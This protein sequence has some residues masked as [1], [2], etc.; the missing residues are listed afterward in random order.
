MF[1]FSWVRWLRSR[2]MPRVQQVRK[3]INRGRTR[4]ALEELEQRLA[5][6]TY[7]WDGGGGDGSWR[8]PLNWVSNTAPTAKVTTNDNLIF[9]TGVSILNTTN[10]LLGLNPFIASI[11]FN[12]GGYTVGGNNLTIGSGGV[13][14]NAGSNTVNLNLSS[15]IASGS[16]FSV[17]AGAGLTVG[18]SVSSALTS[19]N[20]IN[21]GASSNVTVSGNVSLA[22]GASGNQLF[23]NA[24]T[25]ANVLISGSLSGAGNVE[26][27]KEGTGSLT[28]RGNNSG[29]GSAITVRAGVV[30]IE[31]AS[32]LGSTSAGTTVQ[33]NA[34]VQVRSGVGT[35]SENIRVS[36]SGVSGDG[37]L[38]NSGGANTWAGN[39]VMDSSSVL[40]VA[41]GSIDITGVI[42]D[43]GSGNNLTKEG[44]GQ[45]I[46]SNANTYRGLTT[47]N[48]GVVTIKH[49]SAL[50]TQGTAANG[51]VVQNLTAQGKVATLQLDGSVSP[52]TILDEQ[53]T[54]NGP[55][56]SSQ[57][58]LNNVAGNNVWA[59][60]IILGG[61]APNGS[62]ANLGVASGTTLLVS[63]VIST[64]NS[65][66]NVSKVGG[67]KLIL[68]NANT[69]TGITFI[70]SGIV[71]IRDS[72][73]LGPNGSGNTVVS[74]GA[75]LELEVDTGFDAHGRNLANDSVL[76]LNGP[77]P[78][79]GLSINENITL[80]GSGISNT[81]AL[82][83]LSGINKYVGDITMSGTVAIGVEPDPDPSNTKAYFTDDYSLTITG[84]LSGNN[85]RKVGAGHMILPEDNTYTGTTRIE[86]GWIT[87]QSEQALGALAGGSDASQPATT[88]LAGAAL[89]LKPLN[90]G[91]NF[92]LIKN[93]VLSGVGVDHPFPIIDQKGALMSLGGDNKIGGPVNNRTSAIKLDG[94][95]G[96][97]VENAFDE[98][99]NELTITAQMS[100]FGSTPGGITK[101]GSRRL[102]LQGE[103]T[104][105]GAVD[106]SEGVILTQNATALGL[107]TTGAFTGTNTYTNTTTT[108]G[109]GAAELQAFSVSGSGTFTLTFNGVSTGNLSPSSSA[110]DVEAALNGLSSMTD[111]GG[112]VAVTK[113]KTNFTVLFGGALVGVNVLELVITGPGLTI[114]KSTLVQG[115]GAALEVG[116][117]PAIN[118]G[119]ISAGIAIWHERLVLGGT[120]NVEFALAPLTLRSNDNL[121]Q[122]PVT[123]REDAI[124]QVPL[125]ARLVFLGS[126]DDDPNT[127]DSGSSLTLAGGGQMVL[128]GA[129]TYRGTTFVNEGL[130]VIQN[131]LA[132]GGTGSPE[133]QLVTITGATDG[134]FTLTFN[135][136]TTNALSATASETDVENALNALPSVAGVGGNVTVEKTGNVYTVLFD[137]NLSSLNQALMS[138]AGAGGTSAQVAPLADGSGGTIVADGAALQLQGSLTV[139]GE[140]LLLEGE[141]TA[142]NSNVPVGWFPI[143]PAPINGWP[144]PGNQAVTGRITGVV[145][146][147]VNTDIIYIS[148]A[149]GGA[150][151]TI[152]GGRTWSPLFDYRNGQAEVQQITVGGSSGTFTLSFDGADTAELPVGAS[153]LAVQGALNS[154]LTIGGAFGSVTVSKS[155]NTY[156][157]TFAG[158]LGGADVSQITGSGSA[159]VT[160]TPSTLTE[161]IDSDALL[162][163]GTISMDPSDARTIYIGTG[164]ANNSSDSYYGT[165]IYKSVDSGQTWSLVTGKQIQTVTVS[166]GGGSSTFRLSFDGVQTS[167]MNVGA[168]ETTVENNL[169]GLSTIQGRG[170]VDVTKTGN[171][172]KIEFLGG[173]ATTE[174][175][176]LV[177][178]G[179]SGARVS[180]VSTSPF[181]PFAG[182]GISK[183]IIDS[184][185]SANDRT[186]YVASGDGGV[187]ADEVQRLRFSGISTFKLSF[188]GVD[189]NG[190]IVT[191]E[192][193]DI[194]YNN[195]GQTNRDATA[196]AIKTALEALSNIG[197][198]GGI[199]TV[200]PPSGGFGGNSNRYTVTFGG[201]LTQKNVQ[202]LTS[203][204]GAPASQF[205]SGITI[206]TFREGGGGKVVNGTPGGAGVWRF[207]GGAW[208]NLTAVVSNNRDSTA[209]TNTD[210]NPNPPDTPGP[211]DDYRISFPQSSATWSDVALVYTSRDNGS[212]FGPV[213]YAALGIAGGNANNGVFWSKNPTSNSPIWYVGAPGGT[214]SSPATAPTA[215]DAR[216][217]SQFPAGSSLGNIKLDAVGGSTLITTTVYASTA[218]S[219]GSLTA[220]YKT[221]DGGHT[222]AAATSPGNYM[223]NL[224]GYANA[225]LASGTTI[226]VAGYEANSSTHAQHIFRSTDSGSNWTDISKDS[227][228]N[229]PHTGTH[230][231]A[232]VGGR[233]FTGTD[234]GLWALDSSGWSDLNGNL[235]ISQVNSVASHPFDLTV[236]YAGVQNNGTAMFDNALGWTAIDG[237]SGG[238]I[239]VDPSNPSILYHVLL[240]PGSSTFVRRSTNGGASWTNILSPAGANVP[241]IL[242]NVDTSRL[243]VGG[244]T[245]QESLDQG[246]TWRGLSNPIVANGVAIPSYQGT[247]VAD[248]GFNHVTDIGANTYDADTVYVTN[249]SRVYVTKDHGLTWVERTTDLEDLG[250][251]SSLLVD[252]RN[253]DTVYVTRSA[254]GGEKVLVTTDAGRSWTDI[255]NDLPDM[256]VWKLVLDTRSGDIYVGT[257]LGVWRLES[258]T[259]TWERFGAGMP[260]VQVRDL[261]LNETT[262]ILLAGTYGRSVYQLF[263]GDTLANPGALR[264]VSGAS[265]WAGP[266]VLAGDTTIRVDGTQAIQNGISAAS[267]NLIGVVGELTPGQN[268]LLV[269][270]GGGDL[271]LSGVNVYGGTT[272]VQAGLLSIKN[273]QALGSAGTAEVQTL[274]IGGSSSGTFTL[275][276]NGQTTGPLSATAS[277]DEVR[278]A[279]NALSSMQDVGGVASVNQAGNVYTITFG[280]SLLGYDQPELIAASAD[281]AD[282]VIATVGAGAGATIIAAGAILHLQSNLDLEPLTLGGDGASFNGHNTGALRNVSGNNTY[283]G[284]LTLTGSTTIGVDSGSSLTISG[285]IDDGAGAFNLTK[286]LTGTLVLAGANSYGGTTNVNQGILLAAN[287]DALGTS[288]GGTRVLN[289]AQLQLAGGITVVDEDLTLSG[290]GISGAGALQSLSGQNT[291]DGDLTLDFLPGFSPTTIPPDFVGFGVEDGSTLIIDG[292]I[293]QDTVG[294]GSPAN[295][296]VTKTGNG[297]LVFKGANSYGGLT[298]VADGI[299]NIQ[300]STALGTGG[301]ASSGTVIADGAILELEHATGITLNGE[302]LTLSGDGVAGGGVVRNISGNNTFAG[303]QNVNLQNAVTMVVEGTSSLTFEGA[304]L[305]PVPPPATPVTLTKTGTGTLVLK[306]DNVYGASTIDDGTLQVDGKIGDVSID[307]GTLAGSGNVGAMTVTSAGGAVHPGTSPGILKALSA[308]WNSSTLF[309]VELVDASTSG[310]DQLI[311]NGTIEISGAALDGTVATTAVTGDVFTIIS[312]SQ[313]NGEFNGLPDDTVFYFGGRRFRIDYTSTT[314]ELTALKD[315]STIALQ[316]SVTPTVFGQSVD[317]TATVSAVPPGT[318]E[319]TGDVFF[320]DGA[321]PLGFATLSGGVAVFTIST[322]GIGTHPIT[323]S[324]GGD[325]NFNAPASDASVIQ[326]VNQVG[327]TTSIASSLNPS[328][329]ADLVTFT[330]TVA[331]LPPGGGVPTGTVTFFHGATNIGSSSLDGAGQA[332]FDVSNFTV[333][334]HSLSAVYDGDSNYL[335]STSATFTQVVDK[336]A[337]TTS[338]ASSDTT[339]IYGESVTFTATVT[340]VVTPTGTVT[341]MDGA[342][343]LGSDDLDGS[344]QAVFVISSLNAGSH[345]I[346]AVYEGDANLATSTS[347]EV[348]QEIARAATTMIVV[349][350]DNPSAIGQSVTFTATVTGIGV[351][352]GSVLFK[353]GTTTLGTGTLS[354]GVATFST[355]DL[356][357]GTHIIV[358]EYVGDDNNDASS[359]SVTQDV[360][361]ASSVVVSSSDSTTAFGEGVTFTAVVRGAMGEATG[362][363][364]FFS[365]ATSLGAPVTLSGGEASIFV[366]SLAVGL[367]GVVARYSGDSTYVDSESAAFT[368]TVSKAGTSTSLAS[369]DDTSTFGDSVDFTATV[370]VVAPGA[371]APTGF[372]TFRDNGSFLATV[373][374]SGNTAILST[375][376][377]SGGSHSIT[378]TY[379]GDASFSSSS[380]SVGQTVAAAASTTS[381]TST[382]A[383]STYG[384]SVTFTA[385]V[386]SAAGTPT[387]TV[388]FKNGTTELGSRTLSGGVATLSTSA[389]VAGSYT[390][391]AEYQ[392]DGNFDASAGSTSQVVVKASTST[393]LGSSKNPSATGE[394]VTFT[395]TVSGVGTLGGQ[396]IFTIDGI[397]GDPVALSD[398]VATFSTSALGFGAHAITARFMGDANHNGSSSNTVTQD[399]LH[400]T[401]TVVSGTP[402]S[403]SVGESVTFTATI[404]G[405]GALATG[406][407][408]FKDNGVQIGTGTATDG[409]ATFTTSALLAGTHSITAHYAGDSTHAGSASGA[410]SYQVGKAN[411]ST[412]VVSSASPS[413]F[414]QSVTF[415][416]TVTVPGTTATGTVTFMDGS[417]VLG[418]RTLSG[419]PAT[420]AT[421]SL[422]S[423]N[424]SITVVYNGDTN[425]LGSTSSAITQTVTFPLATSMK[426]SLSPAFG[427]G[428]NSPFTLSV[429][430]YDVFGNVAIGHNQ[431]V[432]LTLLSAPVGGTLTGTLSKTFSSGFVSFSDLRVTKAGSYTIRITSG[433]LVQDITVTTIGRRV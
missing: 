5:P 6:A 237:G 85:L 137:G 157:I 296:G 276:F 8:N 404:S 289:G 350:S 10:D 229:G 317:F 15:G 292:V 3:L 219:S 322:L 240:Q 301:G 399:V 100:D 216:S 148:T 187:G 112:S 177:G 366:S 347:N 416:A 323:A 86:Q 390:I 34:E 386:S 145:A 430:A 428:I 417:T 335:G 251:L 1:P 70:Q 232:L 313:V 214:N 47:I 19:G 334:S 88:V 134:S 155:G 162:Y 281:G 406:S 37:V 336:A 117:V 392:G 72:K 433:T 93:L 283:S 28:L 312:A 396:V 18:G 82:R 165:G 20:L 248:P 332:T 236:A 99:E 348:T 425:Y 121:W 211:D 13:V 179:T 375:S 305:E 158:N 318:G 422:S 337:T 135:G 407:V 91:D 408:I 193:G 356:A 41:G 14:S 346:T 343:V 103:G 387:G 384:D 173:L 263:M 418:T 129:N 378:A 299:L 300:N 12:G 115:D 295:F 205:G 364:E 11:T 411:S 321:T 290:T 92:N 256:P 431:T 84:N 302:R 415:T 401:T 166:G 176:L 383:S 287:D 432:T 391:T 175:P 344:G 398:N 273:G 329:F 97:G 152:N 189:A 218:S 111:V 223:F 331:A 266:I 199:V 294:A 201:S 136:Y 245:L 63:G 324:Y 349:A 87:V 264:A 353:E 22:A 220:V 207:E 45:L 171:V 306:G 394:S 119:G 191:L 210:I 98:A 351:V 184:Q 239:R 192:T 95:A 81:G 200:T 233:L 288:G 31:H 291:W 284:P 259:T 142:A 150:W 429:T 345:T 55:G 143:G 80:S 368:Q 330:V 376:S 269:K 181:N 163:V 358:A 427:V 320:F 365:G 94:V 76:G 30:G 89:H 372:V 340:G 204:P 197:G 410:L 339:T 333:G 309:F 113:D 29:L 307:G 241:L 25:G 141:G 362:T 420:L 109:D 198:I 338:L 170:T 280:G 151:K 9:P 74:T 159:G 67:G 66:H 268:S 303:T 178:S 50:G 293:D 190:D 252:P 388:L 373:A 131:S 182:K 26:L 316:T 38:V 247:F 393:S 369:S 426:A 58:A 363:V 154:L 62:A 275:T 298:T 257:D 326:V 17:A 138:A 371:G 56:V 230:A 242:D 174:I 169:N 83:S 282:P 380:D 244:V 105:G 164:E 168:S 43:A 382:P 400:A 27:V 412:A 262:N 234:G 217:G 297:K 212:N 60:S 360:L 133:V 226:Y 385:T 104:Y 354:A 57:G 315:D 4:L 279:L 413:N 54:L 421:S 36:G 379:D 395:A 172:Y 260:N 7:V 106:I 101:L 277:G 267:L 188:T 123:L 374:L 48:N 409:V 16:L 202:Q 258:G 21:A 24:L 355:S 44:T 228:G 272:D 414:G 107:A 127:S 118:N 249:G 402:S 286:E 35:V 160:I 261:E 389:L 250:S 370:S 32:A 73:A 68:D 124:L 328:T 209:S 419:G 222:W 381:L 161:G 149:G 405:A 156:T 327:T 319:A 304:L 144:T 110:A 203:N 231:L 423:G 139:S 49:S 359:G 46:L 225:I 397:D 42:S 65:P 180:V 33:T 270:Q 53:L 61:P 125:G 75:A 185:T 227:S 208:F 352:T 183:I 108:I 120:G 194:T 285:V 367:H 195:N 308:V 79:L 255:S 71:N 51:T 196:L 213:L 126:I 116:A 311:V 403:S 238:Q 153:A 102:I 146:D 2:M 122:G 39:I 132:L 59:A 265:V 52:L 314:V 341:F 377:L 310:Y 278:D 40:G 64:P 224:G 128:A 424:H 271:V 254:F 114:T 215:V 221:T 274:T 246:S 147:P 342:T 78:K 69:Y 243:L 206:S 96:I 325:A 23:I 361:F 357:S 140:S 77:G 90:P 130:L 186:L 253:R 167:A 235:M